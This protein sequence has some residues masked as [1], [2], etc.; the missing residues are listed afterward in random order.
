[1]KRQIAK[2]IWLCS[3][4]ENEVEIDDYGVSVCP[5]CGEKILPCSQ[6]DMN[7]VDCSRCDMEVIDLGEL[8]CNK[9][10]WEGCKNDD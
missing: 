8:N 5:I 6:Y 9:E 4:C 3:Y 10:I 2:V 7:E 1:M